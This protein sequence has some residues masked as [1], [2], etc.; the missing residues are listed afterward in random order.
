MKQVIATIVAK[1]EPIQGLERPH[2]RSI[3]FSQMIKLNCPGIAREAKPGQFVMVSCGDKCVLPRPFSIH[4][5]NDRSD[6]SLYLAVL[7]G[8]KGTDWLAQCNI[9]DSVELFGPLGNGYFIEPTSRNLLLVAGGMGIAPLYFLAQEAVEKRLSVTL[10][11]GTTTKNPYHEEFPGIRLVRATEDGTVGHRGII[12]DLIVDYVDKA[13]QIFSC[14]SVP[15]YYG[16]AL[17]RKELGLKGKPVQVSLEVRMGCGWGVCYGCTI[18]TKKG[19]K[20]VCTDGPVFDL[21]DIL[22]D[23]LSYL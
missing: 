3:R 11:Y 17:N 1:G 20:Q 23:E 6:V 9:G 18:K 4:H 8:G 15:M 10:L 13:D 5:I 14:G 21:D 2:R 19:L 22:W 12:T 7:E 16:M